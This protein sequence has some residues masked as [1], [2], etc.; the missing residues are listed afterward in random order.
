MKAS[1]PPILMFLKFCLRYV[2]A[3]NYDKPSTKWS[4]VH[5]LSVLTEQPYKYNNGQVVK[6]S[7]PTIASAYISSLYYCMSS[8]TTCG[9]GNIAPNTTAEKLFSCVTMLLGCKYSRLILCAGILRV[10]SL[11]VYI[12]HYR[13]LC[14]PPLLLLTF[15]LYDHTSTYFSLFTEVN[16]LS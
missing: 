9:F 11:Y 4:W 6:D 1:H 8:L 2:I 13:F 10:G 5:M 7:G 14:H 12:F 15:L 3:V 16:L